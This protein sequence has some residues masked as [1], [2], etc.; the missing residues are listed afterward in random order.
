MIDSDLGLSIAW[1]GCI[2]NY[3]ELRRELE[4]Y[5]YR[6]FSHSDTEVLLKAYHRWGDDFVEPFQRHVRVRHR[7]ARQRP[8]AARSGPARNQ[9]ALPDRGRPPDP[10]RLVAA[11]AAGRRRRGHPDRPRRAAPLHDVPLR[12]PG[13]ADDPARRAQDSAGVAARDR[14]RRPA[15][16]HDLL[17]AGLQQARRPLRLVR[18][19]LGRRR[20]VARC[21]PRSSVDSSPTCRSAACCPAGWTPA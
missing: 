16:H 20:A 13:A 7:R 11:G 8:G 9:A 12:R 1:N 6:F 14:A 17:D 2:Y 18:A 10:V 21:A 4:G 15:H 5:G 3:K 19:R